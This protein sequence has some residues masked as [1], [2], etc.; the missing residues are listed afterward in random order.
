MVDITETYEVLR[1]YYDF[2]IIILSEPTFVGGLE[3][4]TAGRLIIFVRGVMLDS[5]Q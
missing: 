4:T 5:N 3:P 2:V 1:L